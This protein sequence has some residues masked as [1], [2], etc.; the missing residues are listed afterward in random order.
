MLPS[1]GVC[2][3]VRPRILVA[4]PGNGLP[5]R[6]QVAC[7]S[8]LGIPRA[9]DIAQEVHGVS[10]FSRGPMA[11]C[12]LPPRLISGGG[13]QCCAWPIPCTRGVNLGR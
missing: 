3:G 9:G 7:P 1:S 2:Y 10:H 6:Q 8:G 11:A 12:P 13:T 5:M 4:L